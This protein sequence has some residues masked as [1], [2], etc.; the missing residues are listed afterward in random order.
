MSEQ[1]SAAVG[2]MA[3]KYTVRIEPAKP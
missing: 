1:R 2:E 3:R